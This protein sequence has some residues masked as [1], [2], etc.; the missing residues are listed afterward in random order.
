MLKLTLLE[1]FSGKKVLNDQGSEGEK[2]RDYGPDQRK[3]YRH[4]L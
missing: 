3:D 4:H 1:K 2:E